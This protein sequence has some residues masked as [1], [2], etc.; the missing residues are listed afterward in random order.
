MGEG[1]NWGT[2]A[3]HS[4]LA[5]LLRTSACEVSCYPHPCHLPA[6][7]LQAPSSSL[8][9]TRSPSAPHFPPLSLWLRLFAAPTPAPKAHDC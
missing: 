7:D 4:S 1:K 8:S 6:S 5:Q 9:S 2:Q 3:R